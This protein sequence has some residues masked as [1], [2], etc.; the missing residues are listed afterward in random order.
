MPGLLSRLL[1][2]RSE[3]TAAA[4]LVTAIVA[5]TLAAIFG[6]SMAEPAEL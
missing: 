4:G 3:L 5:G 1:P 2:R 6:G